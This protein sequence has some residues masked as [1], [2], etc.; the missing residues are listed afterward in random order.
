MLAAREWKHG[1]IDQIY[2]RSFLDTTGDGIG[3]LVGIIE[4]LDYLASFQIDAIRISPIN[5]S[6]MADFGDEITNHSDIAPVFGE[7]A[8]F[9]RL[10]DEAVFQPDEGVIVGASP[11]SDPAT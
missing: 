8:R 11:G 6:P 10:L 5:P 3:G 4:R 9:M 1:V 2:P 7:L